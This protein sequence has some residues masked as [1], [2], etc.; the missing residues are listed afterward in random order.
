MQSLPRP[1]RRRLRQFHSGNN[2]LTMSADETEADNDCCASCGIAE[3]DDIKLMDC[4]ACD[5]ATRA[6]SSFLPLPIDQKK[7]SPLYACCGTTICSGCVYANQKREWEEKLQPACP[8]CRNI[9][10]KTDEEAN[11]NAMKRAKANDPVAM[12]SMGNRLYDEG[13]YV[14]AFE[15]CTKAAE[16]G[17]VVAHSDLPVFYQ[18][19]LGVEKDE[20]MRLYH[21]EKLPL[22]V[23]PGLD[24]I[25][26]V[27][28]EEMIGVIEQ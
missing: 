18:E 8:F 17:D 3:L 26:R 6:Q 27:M 25:L 19:G 5:L 9:L 2:I 11:K 23:I 20:K 12:S 14:G 21:L 16:L 28:R 4:D 10:P 7:K 24:I 13:D 15:Y 22:A 1:W